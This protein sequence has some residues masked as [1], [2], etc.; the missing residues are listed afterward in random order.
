MF[1]TKLDDA[2]K[3]QQEFIEYLLTNPVKDVNLLQVW[4]QWHVLREVIDER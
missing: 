3:N 1:D 4:N 2:T